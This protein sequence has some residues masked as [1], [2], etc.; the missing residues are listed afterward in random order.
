MDMYLI[1]YYSY[2]KSPTKGYVPNYYYYCYSLAYSYVFI[3]LDAQ[4]TVLNYVVRKPWNQ[5]LLNSVKK[6][7][8]E[9]A[10]M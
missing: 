5:K 8:L 9:F 2:T 6:K 10:P 3:G 7:A 4:G 1:N